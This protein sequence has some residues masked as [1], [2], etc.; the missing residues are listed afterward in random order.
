MVR[1][2]P[3]A[4]E[5]ITHL[6]IFLCVFASAKFGQYL[7]F[8]WNTSPAIIWPPTGIAIAIIWVYGY[9][10]TPAV[11][12]GLFVAT[13]TGPTGHLL[14]ALVTTPLAQVT[15][16]VTMVYFL[17]RYGFDETFSSVRNALLFFL[18]VAF[19]CMVAPTI[20]TL[21]SLTT[22]NLTT[23]AYFSWSRAW[24]GYVF[25]CLI[26]FPFLI[27][28]L[29]P[30]KEIMPTRQFETSIVVI[31]LLT[32]VYILFWTRTP[33]ELL[34]L[35]FGAFFVAHFWACLRAPTRIITLFTVLTTVVAI[36]GLFLSPRTESPL[37]TQLLSAELFIL[38]VV[39]I[40]YTF[41]ALVKERAH[42]M[43]ALSESLRKI[44]T[45]NANK[46]EFIAVLAHEL[47]NPLSPIKTTFE[48]LGLQVQEPKSHELIV[49]AQRQVHSMR[50]LL[51]D[52]LDTTRMSQGKFQLQIT[53]S[54]MCAMIQ[55]AIASTQPLFKELGHTIM[56]EG[57]C[58]D[59]VWLDVDPVRFEQVVVNILTNAAKYTNPGGTVRI[60]NYVENDIAVLA[61][62]DTGVGI[63]KEHL[64][65]V[66]DSFWQVDSFL[67][68]ASGGI[69]V[70]L[71]LTKQIVE[72]HNGTITVDSEGEGKGSIFTI[73]IPV[74]K[75]AYVATTKAMTEKSQLPSYKILVADDNAAAA[76]ALATLLTL[77]G[78][79]TETAYTG[80]DVLALVQSFSP[81]IVLLDIG[82]PDMS[83]YEV[84]DTLRSGGYT[85]KIIALTGYGQ[86]EDKEKARTAGF[87]HHLTKPMAI[88][89]F[90]EYLDTL[91]NT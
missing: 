51:D 36:S 47:R 39:P 56:M 34:F 33:G 52:L 5:L 85:K 31:I 13:L 14:P 80:T 38:L 43:K 65:S 3:K 50:R 75:Q 16:H 2:L 32:S 72:M 28:W 71:S 89:T 62:Q 68:R 48:I 79:T 60:S 30:E 83:G 84:V 73:S 7:F 74:S 8:E 63:K 12:L 18:V 20:T 35:V 70:G 6:L 67:P 49:S 55:N 9:R 1:I 24:A 82:L 46:N 27:A 58:D 26:L 81:D 17:R 10:Y 88:A 15:G 53:H 59:T 37:N 78:H 29:K 66:F 76:N 40:I 4:N 22:N 42:T 41:S 69:G 87:D 61:I 25:S 90:E 54:N 21:I 11:F 45:E 23:A 77:K 86:A 44:E 19:G 57:T 64:E 91:S